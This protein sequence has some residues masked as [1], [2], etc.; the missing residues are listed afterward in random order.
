V[1]ECFPY[2]ALSFADSEGP[3]ATRAAPKDRPPP[4]PAVPGPAY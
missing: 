3:N 2:D 1:R 4:C